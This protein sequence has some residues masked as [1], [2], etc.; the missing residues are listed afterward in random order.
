[1][2]RARPARQSPGV[3][4]RDFH[5]ELPT[6]AIATHPCEPRDAARLLVHEPDGAGVTRHRHVRD[7]PDELRAGDLLVLNDTRVLP[8]RVLATRRS[9]G[10]VECLF[11]EPAPEVHAE[12]PR[13]WRALVKPA[14]KL[15]PDERL[16]AGRGVTVRAVS[17]EGE[18]AVWWV[19]LERAPGEP[20][21]ALLAEV[22]AMPLPPYI[23]RP[24]ED[25]DSERYQT[26]YARVPGAVAA[27]TAGLHFTPELLAA[28]A[29]RGVERT[30]V[31]LHVG[32][33][34]FLPVTA[35]RVED[36][37]MH[38]ERYELTAEACAAIARTRARGGRVVAVGTTSVRVLESC[39]DADGGLAPGTGRTQLFLVPGAKFRVVDGL[40]T[41]FHLPGSTL[42]M[43]VSAFVGRERILGL[44]ADAVQRGYRFYSYGDAQL[45]WRAR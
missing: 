24:A 42:L 17:R 38:E 15:A 34:T 39:A 5:Y 31:T 32:A 13:A 41:N 18:S 37:V 26:V 27:P 43:L 35:E 4:V 25:V 45:L 10:R 19:C 29:E 8:A 1:M 7:L 21:E 11:L 3:H 12:A 30:T 20:T 23:D 33:G 36:H 28:L 14:R 9:G 2:D 22:G 40:M 16:D 6:T 44:Y